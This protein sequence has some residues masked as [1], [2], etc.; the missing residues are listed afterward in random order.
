MAN[1]HK[2]IINF[3]LFIKELPTIREYVIL[4]LS[5]LEGEHSSYLFIY[6]KTVLLNLSFLMN[7]LSGKEDLLMKEEAH[8]FLWVTISG[9]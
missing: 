7:K 1:K 3:V 5:N 6:F 9:R 8:S 2:F 4:T